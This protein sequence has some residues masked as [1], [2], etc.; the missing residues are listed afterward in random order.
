MRTS[1]RNLYA[2]C[3]AAF[4]ENVPQVSSWAF[5]AGLYSYPNHNSTV[6][7]TETLPCTMQLLRTPWDGATALRTRCSASG[8]HTD[9]KDI[10]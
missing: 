6:P 1:A 5:A 8:T 3:R 2:P 7:I 10:I 4:P 9:K